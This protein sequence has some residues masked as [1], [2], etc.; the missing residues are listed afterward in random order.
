MKNDWSRIYCGRDAAVIACVRVPTIDS[1]IVL[2]LRHTHTQ[3]SH[4]GQLNDFITG[5]LSV[6]AVA[7][8]V[9][10]SIDWFFCFGEIEPVC[11]S[12]VQ[13]QLKPKNKHEISKPHF[14]SPGSIRYECVCWPRPRRRLRSSSTC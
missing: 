6:I 11:R 12:F 14:L 2:A 4:C 7:F 1:F 9:T 13:P 5:N 10:P 3:R 8:Y